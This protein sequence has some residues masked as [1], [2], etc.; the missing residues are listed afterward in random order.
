[1]DGEMEAAKPTGK[2]EWLGTAARFCHDGDF[3]GMRACARE[4]LAHDLDDV[5]GQALFAQ[6][7]LY[8]GEEET[9]EGI[10][11]RLW[12]T[13]PG[14]LRLLLVA[15]ELYALRFEMRQAISVLKRLWAV[16]QS[17]MGEIPPY[18]L[19]ILERA[20]RILTDACYLLA[21]PAEAAE[22][23]FELV[24]IVRNP[25]AKEEMYSKAL[26][27]LNYREEGQTDRARREAI[28]G[29]FGAKVTM[30]HTRPTAVPDRKMR[31][32]YISPD[33]REHAVANF[34]SPFF[35]NFAKL[36]FNVFCY[37]TGTPDK[38]TQRFKRSAV[39]WRDL[40]E[41]PPQEAARRIYRDHVDI[42][43][44]FS[45]HS[46]GSSI[47]IL[48][49]RPAPIQITGIGDVCSTGLREVDY[50]LS[51]GY[52]SPP[53]RPSPEFSERMA[54]LSD[55]H[56][57][58]DPTILRPL[59]EPGTEPPAQKNGFVTFGSF[60]NFAKVSRE[61][62]VLWRSVLEA[63]PRSKLVIKGK[64]ASVPDGEEE[65]MARL[66]A[67]GIDLSRVELRPY[68]PDYLEQYRDVDIALD[69]TP[70][71]GGLTTC[72][73]LVMGVPVIS[74]KGKTH[75]ARMGTSIL[76][77]A[78]LPEL[79]ASNGMEYVK[80]AARIAAS[81]PILVKFHGGLR[82]VV[83]G[84]RLMDAKR[85]MHSVETMYR[86]LWREYCTGGPK[87]HNEARRYFHGA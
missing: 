7:S 46:Q 50:F 9:A 25:Q 2:E 59:P 20:G 29:F 42:L 26:F 51:D 65:A 78:G 24:G 4:I 69:T 47:P 23:L 74:L 71:T 49:Y 79:V 84:S 30:P 38:I 72:E 62:L 54:R 34:L 44:D 43:V 66:A 3:K 61:T 64:I 53:D 1:M 85:Y 70:F 32:G 41:M 63:V 52:C 80:K 75:A 68:S 19:A 18:D 40:Y 14:H 58:Y 83:R 33:L 82:E 86:E 48:A 36:D 27:L 31:I 56:L 73:A 81:L 87:P 5:D 17:R 35:R 6:A 21:R 76:E 77:N 67:V 55:C 16:G 57:C 39:N 37:M 45:G 13:A 15:G 60:N 11:K 12:D 28:N 8:L 10:V 22:S